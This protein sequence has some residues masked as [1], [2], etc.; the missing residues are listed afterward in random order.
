MVVREDQD[1]DCTVCHQKHFYTEDA[2]TLEGLDRVLCNSTSARC[3]GGV[4]STQ[5]REHEV[6]DIL[7]VHGFHHGIRNDFSRPRTDDH[8]GDFFD[9]RDPFLGIERAVIES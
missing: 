5:R 8:D 2:S 3:N 6:A 1:A 9:E 7:F 4:A